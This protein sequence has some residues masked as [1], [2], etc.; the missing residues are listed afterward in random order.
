MGADN[1]D[2]LRLQQRAHIAVGI[3]LAD[4][5][6]QGLPAIAWTIATTGA[7]TGTV[8][9]LA[10]TAAEQRRQFDAWAV[11]LDAKP[12][13]RTRRDGT[14]TLYAA[15]EVG[16]QPAGAIRAELVPAMDPEAGT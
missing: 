12:T 8:N 13:E 11:Y 9:G 5:V 4:A 15:F 14:S 3:F 7:I 16:G 10:G 6:S 2:R 1:A